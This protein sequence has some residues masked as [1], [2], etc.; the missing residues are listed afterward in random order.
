[1]A[2]KDGG[3]VPRS[4]RATLPTPHRD[5]IVSGNDPGAQTTHEVPEALPRTPRRNTSDTTSAMSS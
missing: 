3:K 2:E 5:L 1:M 4:V